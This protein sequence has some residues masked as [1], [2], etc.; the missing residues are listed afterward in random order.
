MSKTQAIKTVAI[1]INTS[2]NIFNFRLGLLDALRDEGFRIVV[3]APYDD[4]SDKLVD[5]GYEFHDIK[6]NNKGTN[7]FQDLLLVFSFYRLY[8]RLK[9]DVILQYTIKPN[10][11]GAIAAKLA[12]C[13]TINNISGLGTVFLNDRF[14]SKLA[15]WMYRFSLRFAKKVFFQNPHDRELFLE[16]KL[17]SK[18]LTD[19][20]PGSGIDIDKYKPAKGKNLNSPFVFLLVA[21][22]IKDKGIVEYVGAAK[23]I[24]Q[25]THLKKIEFWLLGDLYLGNPTAISQNEIDQWQAQGI[26]KYFHHVDDV[27]SVMNQANCIVL[28]SYREGLSR[29]LLEAA[30]LAKPIITTDVPG[31]KDVVIHGINGYLCKVKDEFDLAAQMEKMLLLSRS[32]QKAMGQKGRDKI[33]AEFD[34][35][36]VIKKYIEEIDEIIAK[37]RENK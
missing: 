22:M 9:P 33:V 8:R 18:D 14:S 35:N 24:L 12:D 1:V 3:I 30:A 2:W 29:V 28:P 13:H 20:L 34:E 37:N 16:N 7:P 19:V 36:F 11:Y 32:A 23:K 15:H 5:L 17:V 4:Y 27:V 6:I 25:N 26:V 21:R 10:I 31:C